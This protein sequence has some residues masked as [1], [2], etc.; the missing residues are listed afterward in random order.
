MGLKYVKD[1][2]YE[3]FVCLCVCVCVCVCV[4]KLAV[5]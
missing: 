2:M 3:K 5:I 4:I 1:R